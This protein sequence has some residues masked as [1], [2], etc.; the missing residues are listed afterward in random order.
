MNPLRLCMSSSFWQER[1]KLRPPRVVRSS[2]RGISA[3]LRTLLENPPG[4]RARGSAPSVR[5]RRSRTASGRTG[6]D[7]ASRSGSAATAPATRM[8][9]RACPCPRRCF[10]QLVIST[11][12]QDLPSKWCERT[13]L[14]YS[15]SLASKFK[16]GTPA[17]IPL[18]ILRPRPAH[19][20]AGELL[21]GNELRAR[22][23]PTQGC[24][25]ARLAV[26]HPKVWQGHRS[27]G[28]A[29]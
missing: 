28:I 9:V 18:H 27:Q 7:R 11:R 13:S 19:A 20:T 25:V 26:V 16:K 23:L 6:Q 5:S 10:E 24:Q 15:C 12:H 22:A 1:P 29:R 21:D 8:R 2:L 17:S 14:L 3:T 4:E